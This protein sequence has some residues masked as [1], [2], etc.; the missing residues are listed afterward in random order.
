MLWRLKYLSVGDRFFLHGREHVITRHDTKI[1]FCTIEFDG[2]KQW[3]N[4]FTY[5][6]NC[7]MK[8]ELINEKTKAA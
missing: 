2:P 7:Q 4:K 1:V 8:V 5:G 6:P 3:P